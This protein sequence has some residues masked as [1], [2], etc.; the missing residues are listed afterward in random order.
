MAQITEVRLVDDLDGG[1]A[2]ES[3][4]FSIDGKSYEI[5]LNEKHAAALRDAFAPFVGSARRAGGSAAVATRQKAFARPARPREETAAIRVW[6]NANGHEVSARGRIPAAV[7]DAYENRGSAPVAR[8]VA[9]APVAQPVVEAT[10]DATVDAA[11]EAKPKRRSRKKAA[12]E[13]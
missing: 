3:V 1:E 12:V 5:D 8:A 2:A 11:V 9:A 7:L 10:V 13:S 6:A 4:A